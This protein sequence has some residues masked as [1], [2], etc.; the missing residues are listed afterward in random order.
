MNLWAI[1]SLVSAIISAILGVYVIYKNPKRSENKWAGFA[2]FLIAIWM[3]A[4]F[5]FSPFMGSMMFL[6]I[7]WFGGV[8]IAPTF[9]N[10]ALIYPEK[11]RLTRHATLRYGPYILTCVLYALILTNSWHHLLYK[12]ITF[13]SNPAKPWVMETGLLSPLWDF[14]GYLFIVPAIVLWVRSFFRIKSKTIRK[15]TGL[16]LIG[17]FLICAGDFASILTFI[18]LLPLFVVPAISLIAFSI[19]RYKLFIIEPRA[20]EIKPTEPVYDLPAGYIYPIKEPGAEKSFEIFT[21]LVTHGAYGLC[22]SRKQPDDVRK[23]YGLEKTPILW[24]SKQEKIDYAISPTDVSLL[25]QTIEDFTAKTK[26]SVILLEGLEY[27]IANNDFNIVLRVVEDINDII[28]VNKSRVILP[29]NPETLIK[30]ELALL[31]RGTRT[32]LE[33]EGRK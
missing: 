25:A 29:I 23:K 18:A 21:G 26:G 16:V 12:S 9:L 24:L 4:H 8:F 2:I 10:L 7:G 14:L 32:I 30:K 6:E 15:G 22:I 11:S 20:E 13:T 19:T 17:V 31:E 5:P 28:K 27:L 33:K 3:L 1:P